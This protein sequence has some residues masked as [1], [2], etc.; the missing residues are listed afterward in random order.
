[1]FHVPH[2]GPDDSYDKRLF[3][4]PGQRSPVS[5]PPSWN[6]CCLAAP[7]TPS[8]KRLSRMWPLLHTLVRMLPLD[9]ICNDLDEL[10]AAGADTVSSG[11]KYSLQTASLISWQTDCLRYSSFPTR[12][13]CVSGCPS[14]GASGNRPRNRR[15]PAAHIRGQARPAICRLYRLRVSSLEPWCVHRPQFLCLRV[16]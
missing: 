8:K 7:S 11:H 10:P 5:P 16:S 13:F 1:M 4:Q 15:H 9:V 3:R 14:Q 6:R 2:I 12:R